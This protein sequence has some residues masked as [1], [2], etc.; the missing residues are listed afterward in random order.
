VFDS[1]WL[2]TIKVGEAKCGMDKLKKYPCLNTP[3]IIE[4]LKSSLKYIRDAVDNITSSKIDVL[5]WQLN[6]NVRFI[7]EIG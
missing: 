5:Q 1:A 2:N 6:L 7:K 3:Y 4:G